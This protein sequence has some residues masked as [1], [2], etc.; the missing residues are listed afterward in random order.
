MVH[1]IWSIP[2]TTFCVAYKFMHQYAERKM[3]GILIFSIATSFLST[4]LYCLVCSTFTNLKF[5]KYSI[6]TLK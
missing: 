5:D 1:L 4:N 6:D 2:L 3:Q